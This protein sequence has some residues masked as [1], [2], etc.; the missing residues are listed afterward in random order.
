MNNFYFN[1]LFSVTTKDYTLSFKSLGLV[2]F[3]NVFDR[4]HSCSPKL[5]LFDLK[6]SKNSNIVKYWRYF[7]K[8]T[9][10]QCIS[11]HSLG[12]RTFV[13]TL[14]SI[15]GRSVMSSL[16]TK[17]AQVT[18]TETKCCR[19][20]R[21]SLFT[22]M[23]PAAVSPDTNQSRILL[24]VPMKHWWQ[25]QIPSAAFKA[26]QDVVGFSSIRPIILSLSLTQTHAQ[27]KHFFH[28]RSSL[29]Q[30]AQAVT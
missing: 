17:A 28:R 9:H 4:S 19:W 7:S 8:P 27:P 1:N 12:L 15:Y 18:V 5:H 20:V 25:D 16:C 21:A 22:A 14:I 30:C 26:S 29:Q 24:P 13:E 10:V 2:R 3:V 6:Y 23:S 11:L